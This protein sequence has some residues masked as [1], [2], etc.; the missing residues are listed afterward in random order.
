MDHARPQQ[1]RFGDRGQALGQDLGQEAV[2]WRGLMWAVDRLAEAT[3]EPDRERDRGGHQAGGH[4]AGGHRPGAPA[5]AWPADASQD[6]ERYRAW[7][8]NR[9]GGAP[10]SAG[11][12]G[13]S[14]SVV[15]PVFK[16]DGWVLERCVES[17]RA[18]TWAGWECCI[19]DDGSGDRDL[20]RYLRRLAARDGRVKVAVLERNEGI[21]A[22]TNRALSMATADFVALLDHDD[23]LTP[24]ALAAVAGGLADHP[25][26]DVVYTDEDKLD[27]EG[28]PFGPRFKPD[29]SPDYLLTT[30]YMGHLL[31][32]RRSLLGELGGMRAKMDGSQD[33]DLM[34]RATEQ[35]R[36]VLHVPE[37]AYHWRVVPGSA[38]GDSSAKPWAYAAS[39]RA[40]TSALRRRGEDAQLEPGP[41]PGMWNARRRLAPEVSVS[42]VVCAFGG[43]RQLRT[44][45][46]GLAGMGALVGSGE[47][48][49]G[50]VGAVPGW[51]AEWGVGALGAGEVVVAAPA[52]PDLEA[53]ALLGQLTRRR[54]SRVVTGSSPVIACNLAARSARGALVLF[55]DAGVTP[56]PGGWLQAMAEHAV[57]PE[58]GPV[59]ARLL[60]PGGLVRHVGLVLGLGG[61]PAAPVLEGLP[62]SEYGYLEA[63]R[64]TRNWSAVS[65]ACLMIC[66]ELLADLG[67]LD[68]EMGPWADV[69]LC[70]RAGAAGRRT[71]LCSLAELTADLP[72]TGVGSGWGQG[73]ARFLERWGEVVRAGDPYSS[74]HMSRLRPECLLPEDNEEEAARWNELIS[75]P[76]R[77]SRS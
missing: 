8:A 11:T 74:P 30:P 32:I 13:P 56:A 31:V 43:A 49:V 72:P 5:D 45:A 61:L 47:V 7:L 2:A 36:S 17:V 22:A 23:E 51:A 35:A 75:T 68:E 14:F 4:Q 73:G 62:A 42:V 64:V 15:V 50:S 25:W 60:T 63:A 12:G 18:Q 28:R 41:M 38:A 70:L 44:C 53:R 57:R 69:D 21:S 46:D 26:A 67:Y 76:E 6:H 10:G 1:D 24:G 66:R 40:L 20:S 48:V 34:L 19:C 58:V 39:G 77:W 3:A 27:A 29:W 52:H 33:Y 54:G 16:T 37:V 71:V 55:L 59:G 65:G 9:P